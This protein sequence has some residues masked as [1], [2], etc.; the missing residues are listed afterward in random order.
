MN[1]SKEWP[2]WEDPVGH[3]YRPGDT[4]A[5]AVSNYGGANLMIGTV[6]RINR[7]NSQ[8]K[9]H[10]Y[11]RVDP[12]TGQT[13][14]VPSCTVTIKRPSRWAQGQLEDYTYQDPSNIVKV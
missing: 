1:A 11:E 9:P 10:G 12:Q 6:T 14:F 5:V 3:V 8:G 2:E 13:T 4:V 7:V